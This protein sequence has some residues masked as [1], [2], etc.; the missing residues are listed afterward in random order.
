MR[1]PNPSSRSHRLQ[2]CLLL[3]AVQPPLDTGGGDACQ[4]RH[5]AAA[6]VSLEE[7]RTERGA[8]LFGH[9]AVEHEAHSGIDQCQQIHQFPERRITVGKEAL[10]Q[11]AR[12]QTQQSLRELRDQEK[13]Q[14]GDK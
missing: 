1:C 8:E 4:T 11:H 14:H 12:Q 2:W 9:Q 5:F 6:K 3:S 10:L 7:Q 13:H